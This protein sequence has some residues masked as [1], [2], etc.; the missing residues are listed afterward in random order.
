MKRYLWLLLAL[1]LLLPLM[2]SAQQTTVTATIKDPNGV[3][4]AFGSGRGSISCPGNQ[5]PTY[6]GSPLARTITITGLDGNGT[7]TQVFWDVNAIQPVGCAWVFSICDITTAYCFTTPPLNG[8]TGNAVNMSSQISAYA[9]VLP[10]SSGG[11]LFTFYPL[12]WSPSISLIGKGNSSYGLTLG[13]NVTSTTIAFPQVAGT[14]FTFNIC[15]PSSGGI[16]NYTF[17]PPGSFVGFPPIATG[18]GA[19]TPA[20]MQLNNV[21]QWTTLTSTQLA[22]FYQ[23][24]QNNTT[25]ITQRGIL[26]CVPPLQC[27]DNGAATRTDLSCPN[28]IASGGSHSAGC[29][30]DPGATPG[31]TKFLREDASWQVPPGAGSLFPVNSPNPAPFNVD[32]QFGGPNPYY[33]VR[34]AGGYVGDNYNTSVN[35]TM[36]APSSTLTISSAQD[37]ANGMGLV[38]L[39]AGPAP[40]ISTP[41]GVTAVPLGATGS[42]TYNYCVVDEDYANGRTVCSAQGNT[43]TGVT[44]LGIQTATI[45]N[46]QRVSGV[47]TITTSAAHHF[48]NGSQVNI[49]GT[50]D[51][52]FEGA[53]TLTSASGSTLTY[54]QYGAVDVPSTGTSGSA[55]VGGKIFVTWN[56]PVG[57]TTL[58]H[59]VYRCL[60]SCGS[61]GSNY[62]LAGVAQG[63]DSSFVDYG[64][65]ITAANIGD[66][67]VPATAPTSVNNQWLS[68][69]ISSGGGTTVLTLAAASTNPVSGVKVLHD[70]TPIITAMC[71]AFVTGQG[72]K[73]YIP[74]AIGGTN[75]KFPINST[76]NLGQGCSGQSYSIYAASPIWANGSILPGA[77]IFGM[78][79]GN[80]STFP[81]GYLDNY[82]TVISGFAYPLVDFIPNHSGNSTMKNLV[83]V[84][85]Q[86]YQAAILQDSDTLG[87]GSTVLN[88]EDVSLAGSSGNTPYIMKGGFGFFWKGGSWSTGATSFNSPPAALFTVNCGIGQ[89]GQ[90]GPAIVYTDKTS[91]FG[92]MV[93][94]SCGQTLGG[95][96]GFNHME[97][98]EVLMEN[99]YIPVLRINITGGATVYAVD[100]IKTS[101]SDLLGGQSTPM[102][103]V[104]NMG[105]SVISGLTLDEPFCA[106]GSQPAFE[107]STSLAAYNGLV[108]KNQGGCN[109]VG[110]QDYIDRDGKLGIDF[111]ANSEIG[112]QNTGRIF[113]QI[114]GLPAPPVS[115]VVSAGGS[116]P[117]GS[118]T[119]TVAAIDNDGHA[120][121]VSSGVVA[122]TSGGNQTVTVTG[123]AALPAGA[124]GWMLYRDNSSVNAGCSSVPQF[125][126]PGFVFV[127]TFAANCA[128]GPPTIGDAGSSSMSSKGVG[129]TNLY[130]PTTL[131]PPLAVANVYNLNNF[132]GWPTFNVGGS[133]FQHAAHTGT[134]TAGSCPVNSATPYV[135]SDTTCGAGGGG[136]DPNPQ[137]GGVFSKGPGTTTLLS[138]FSP[139]TSKG[140]FNYGWNNP[141]AAATQPNWFPVGV[142][143]NPNAE[144]TCAG[145]TLNEFN[146]AG[147][148]ICSGTTTST[149]NLPALTG[150]NINYVSA[151]YNGNSGA[152]TFAP[153]GSDA[154][155]FPTCPT[156]WICRLFSDQTTAPG[157]WKNIREPTQAAMTGTGVKVVTGA[158]AFTNGH[159][160]IFDAN[161]NVIDGGAA[162]VLRCTSPAPANGTI[163]FYN[164]STWVCLAPNSGSVRVLQEDASGNPSWV[165]AGAGTVTTTGS[166]VAGQMGVMSGASSITGKYLQDEKQFTACN[167]NNNL[168][169]N[170]WSIGATNAPT[171]TPRSGTNAVGCTLTFADGN[172]AYFDLHIPKDWSGDNPSI[173]IDVVTT[174][175]TA[176]H[177]I[178]PQIQI[179]C[180]KGDGSTTDDVAFNAAHSLGTITTNT[181]ANQFWTTS[182]VTLNGTDMTA[183]P[184]APL[185]QGFLM[186][187]KIGRATDS[188][189]NAQFYDA[190]V[191]IPRAMATG[192]Q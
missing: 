43:A 142:L 130:M 106:T 185:S 71:N 36:T 15:Q 113:Y 121:V 170:G 82:T 59:Y 143:V 112:L 78:P 3:P 133:N 47:V 191:T 41:T 22:A 45:T 152:M 68:T 159:A 90:N 135:Y 84:A 187:F 80:K 69:T 124:V 179:S 107:T 79:S 72:G 122:V 103:D 116:V 165:A 17:S 171:V 183:C 33:D 127:D 9:V 57:Y 188:N 56:A 61:I 102:F 2:A 131:T 70:N 5:Q 29:T 125:T 181:T 95:S 65:A 58:R 132:N 19:C 138:G 12:T 87:S 167:Q 76:L 144:T 114:S 52:S 96:G 111:Y 83:L 94:D 60:I 169:G 35:G 157:H 55:Q 73:I 186:H 109:N 91:I 151:I 31:T 162:P 26:N 115:A 119:Y 86:P 54:N 63:Q 189:A 38:V 51:T 128:S 147:L 140:F 37:Y 148:L 4:Y 89:T 110:A 42:T 46:R 164:G 10:N 98:K 117:V 34:K 173:T 62:T 163:E 25:N 175:T 158:G 39:G 182:N 104:T 150:G 176:S 20:I 6:N 27:A 137:Y 7:F 99:A 48:I 145:I 174:D 21:G 100:F 105:N 129:T 50:G 153:N 11:G 74:A 16:Y 85:N 192:A 81:A 134:W 66:G 139:P 118:H 120:T 1:T 14:I 177:T 88:F 77:S 30:P 32:V 44:T 67:D 160:A 190:V 108:I 8:V 166:P 18:I 28:F 13:G 155:D 93:W 101:Y 180:A 136:M 154:I 123:P 172:F 146:R 149:V 49:T 156:L 92:G 64:F 23:Q 178:I 40:T 75:S 53:F 97:F 184:T 24:V 161:S 141:T 168:G 126:T